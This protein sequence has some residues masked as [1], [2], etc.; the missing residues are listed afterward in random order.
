MSGNVNS[1]LHH[2]RILKMWKNFLLFFFLL[3]ISCSCCTCILILN[4]TCMIRII[5]GKSVQSSVNAFSIWFYTTNIKFYLNG[6][7]EMFHVSRFSKKKK[8]FIYFPTFIIH[9][10]SNDF[11][12]YKSKHYSI[13]NVYFPCE[14]YEGENQREKDIKALIHYL[15]SVHWTTTQKK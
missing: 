14:F 11:C 12:P 10:M 3:F 15:L 6:I 1:F 9:C 7:L 13:L 4:N 8:I 2:F 5:S